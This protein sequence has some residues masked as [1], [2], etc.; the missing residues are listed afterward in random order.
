MKNSFHGIANRL[1]IA[2]ERNSERGC[3]STETSETGLIILPNCSPKWLYQL[4]FPSAASLCAISYI[5][6]QT[7]Y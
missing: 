7:G 3:M 4:T 1:D 5:F 6:T 2:E